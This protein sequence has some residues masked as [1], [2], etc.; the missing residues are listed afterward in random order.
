MTHFATPG[1]WWH[2]RQLPP[3]VQALADKNFDLL[4]ANSRHPSLRLKL[5]GGA[6]SARVGLGHRALARSRTEGLVWF[7]IGPHDEYERIIGGG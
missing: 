1:F 3:D 5:V 6:W 2:Y 4:R 7:W